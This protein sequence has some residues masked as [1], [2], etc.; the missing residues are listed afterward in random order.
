MGEIRRERELE[1]NSS[2]GE[3]QQM[4]VEKERRIA[5]GRE[6]WRREMIGR[7]NKPRGKDDDREIVREGKRRLHREREMA[8]GIEREKIDLK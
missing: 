2:Q 3:R 5:K 6:F 8:R 4:I 1:R 7:E